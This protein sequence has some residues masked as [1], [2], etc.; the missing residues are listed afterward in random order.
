MRRPLR[1]YLYLYLNWLWDIILL[2]NVDFCRTEDSLKSG[3]LVF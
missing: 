1:L 3:S 2:I